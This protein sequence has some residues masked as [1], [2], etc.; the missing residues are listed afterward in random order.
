MEILHNLNS[1]KSLPDTHYN[2]CPTREQYKPQRAEEL[3][4]R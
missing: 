4:F 3:I 1:N 2:K